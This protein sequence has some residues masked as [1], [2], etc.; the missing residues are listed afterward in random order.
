MNPTKPRSSPIF[1]LIQ[2]PSNMRIQ[3]TGNIF[4]FSTLLAAM[5][6]SFA[7]CVPSRQFNDLK[8]K[9]QEA[10]DNNTQLK[11]QNQDLAA[12]NTELSAAIVDLKKRIGRLEEDTARAA[13]DLE[14]LTEVHNQLNSAY[15]KLIATNEKLMSGSSAEAKKLMTQLNA[16]Q[17]E[18]VKKE[19]ALKQSTKELEEKRSELKQREEKLNELQSILNRKDSVV[20][21]LKNTVSAA[22]LGF[23]DQGLTVEQKN[24]KVYVSLEERLLFA[25]GSTVVDP[26]GQE[27][28]KQ[29]AKVLEQKP[30]INVM[31]EGHT[32]DVPMKG[33]GE[34]KDNWDLSVLRAT[35]VVK[36]L[37]G[38]TTIDPKRLSAAGRGE[39]FPIE[40][41]KT[42]EAR[43][44]N[45]RT[46]IILTPKLDELLKVLETN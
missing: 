38:G 2:I 18:L 15:E 25:S 33:T 11:Q 41:A 36:I 30:D 4:S 39:H 9:Y 21:A 17:D 24:G 12:N 46:E 19:D 20:N 35:A 45:R 27:A 29:L 40:A 34:I 23:K 16:T 28:L 10:S 26:K 22:L 14:H 1:T 31:V 42:P 8:A 32:D 3:K 13:N 7:A 44:K 37:L 5:L 6:L 43:K